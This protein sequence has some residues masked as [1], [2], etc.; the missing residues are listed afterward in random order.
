[1]FNRKINSFICKIALFAI[2]FTSFAPAMSHALSNRNGVAFNQEICSSNG[3][4]I[5]IQV[6][7]TKGQQ[8]FTEIDLNPN[9]HSRPKSLN[10]HLDHCP[11][12]S[13][14]VVLDLPP[15][16]HEVIIAALAEEAKLFSAFFEPVMP[17]FSVV[18]LLTKHR[19]LSN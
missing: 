14:I 1:M 17:R 3:Q 6:T 9:T 13:N 11:F 4:K 18:P 7:T 12:C 5:Y 19:Q 15:S 10:H 8:Q 2:V 16:N